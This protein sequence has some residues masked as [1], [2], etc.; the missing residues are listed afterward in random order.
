MVD[1]K[2]GSL[3]FLLGEEEMP[4]WERGSEAW[5]VYLG[6]RARARDPCVPGSDTFTLASLTSLG[7]LTQTPGPS[8]LSWPQSA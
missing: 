2:V 7:L 1:K 8:P 3:E 5:S 6:G 4:V